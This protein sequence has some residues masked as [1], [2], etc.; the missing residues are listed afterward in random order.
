[1]LRT[2]AV[3]IRIHEQPATCFLAHEFCDEYIVAFR[4]IDTG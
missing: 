4:N 3:Q 2:C 1:M